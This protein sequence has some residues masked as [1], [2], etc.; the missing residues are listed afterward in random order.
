MPSTSAIFQVGDATTLGGCEPQASV[1]D[2]W[3]AEAFKLHAAVETAF[4]NWATDPG[5]RVLFTTYLGVQF[6]DMK[7]GV[8]STAKTNQ[9]AWAAIGCKINI[10]VF[11]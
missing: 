11:V 10:S 8:M 4:A 6:S 5:L 1:T 2:A 7:N 9:A 3:I